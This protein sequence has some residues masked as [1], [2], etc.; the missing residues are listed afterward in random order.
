MREE[1][2][3]TNSVVPAQ[4]G[5]QVVY[6]CEASRISASGAS[7]DLDSGLRRNDEVGVAH[8][9]VCICVHLWL[10]MNFKVYT[11]TR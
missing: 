3:I 7:Y 10:K 2:A 6:L 5:T 11:D 4:A 1:D 8:L 9:S